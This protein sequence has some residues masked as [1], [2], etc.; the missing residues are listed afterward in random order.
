MTEFEW[1]DKKSRT[2]KAKHRV[3]FEN[4][5]HALKDELAITEFNSIVDGEERWQTTGMSKTGT[6][7][8]VIHTI[9]E[10]GAEILRI[11]SARKANNRE[12]R[13]YGYC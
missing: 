7:L 3:S 9:Q 8:F 5:E 10:N 11:I 13:K 4:A 12:R 6:L 1:D 2:N